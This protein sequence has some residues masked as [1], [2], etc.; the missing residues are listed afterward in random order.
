MS[1]INRQ[2]MRQRISNVYDLAHGAQSEPKAIEEY[3][4]T[5]RKSVD[6]HREAQG[7]ASDFNKDIG[8]I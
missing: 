7:S 5:L 3:V 2:R 1:S 4:K 8:S 6:I